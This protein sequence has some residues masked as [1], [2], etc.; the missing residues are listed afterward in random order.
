MTTETI[1]GTV[2]RVVQV[3]GPV[4]DVEFP[5]DQL[6]QIYDAVEITIEGQDVPLVAEVQQHLGNDWVRT[7]AMDSTDGLQRGAK[8]V[9]TGGPISV[10]VGEGTLG[11]IF[12]VLGRTIDM[13]GPVEAA[14]TRPIHSLPP[15]FT[16]QSTQAE[17]FET[18]LKVIDL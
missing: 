18:G 7:V 1:K 15:S 13:K 5:P 8:A 12:N 17:M 6:P 4:V 11:R 9:A 16:D 3:L 10:P 14:E 2:G